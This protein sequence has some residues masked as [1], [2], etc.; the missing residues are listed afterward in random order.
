MKLRMYLDTS[1]ISAHVDDRTP[2]RRRETVG[3]WNHLARYDV[4]VSELTITE[5]K[6]TRDQAI[7]EQ[8]MRLINPFTI[9][10]VV[11]E[12]RNLAQNYMKRGVF[13]Q[14]EWRRTLSMLLSPLS[15][16]AK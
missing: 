6:A 16:G 5:I 1:V 9:L 11:E 8:M 12:A 13:S 10:P 15:R 3:F 2:E 14:P 4:Q 7:R